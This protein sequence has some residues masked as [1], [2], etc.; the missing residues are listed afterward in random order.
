MD[1]TYPEIAV[2]EILPIAT[3]IVG[4]EKIYA[5]QELHEQSPM[6]KGFHRYRRIVV[7]RNGYPAEFRQDMGSV[8]L[9]RGT[10][11]ITIVCS[12]DG[13]AY[14]SVDEVLDIAD[15]LRTETHIDLLDW[16]GLDKAKI[17]S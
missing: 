11:P 9:W 16:L 13:I 17:T 15:H 10:R 7:N 3:T 6:S 1:K 8:S 2:R 5:Y 14:Y 12:W 4:D